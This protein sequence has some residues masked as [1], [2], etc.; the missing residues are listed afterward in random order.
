[1]SHTSS[2]RFIAYMI[3][4]EKCQHGFLLSLKLGWNDGR[5][6]IKRFTGLL[7]LAGMTDEGRYYDSLEYCVV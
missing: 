4:L 3:K 5:G 7:V 6:E 2:L 1:M